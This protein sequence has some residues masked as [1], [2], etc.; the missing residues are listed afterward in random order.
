MDIQCKI[1]HAF[2]ICAYGK[3]P[4]LEECIQSL[5]GQKLKSEIM[6][7]TSTPNDNIYALAKKYSL[8]VVVNH[9]EKGLAG[10]WNF[11][12]GLPST[13]LVTLAHQDD[14]YQERYTDNIVKAFQEN[15]DAIILFTDYSELRSGQNVK[16]N[17]LLRV[18]RILLFP[19][20]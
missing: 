16:S 19:L 13:D 18:K 12:L 6:I 11:A 14:I 5:Q 1:S 10:D 7:A 2:V 17:R 20:R 4:Y 3:S 15:K 8:P 9:G